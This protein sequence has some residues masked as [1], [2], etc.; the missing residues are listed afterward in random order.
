M[1]VINISIP[2]EFLAKVDNY[3]KIVKEKRSEFFIN[4]AELY[5]K[6]IEEKMYFER[7]K[8]AFKE[9]QKII[10]RLWDQGLIEEFDAVEEIRKMRDERTKELLRRVQ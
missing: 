1:S 7:R 8:K 2:D 10:K 9:L 6:K 4:A 3:K 5:F